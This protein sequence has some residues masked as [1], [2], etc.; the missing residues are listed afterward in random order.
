MFSVSGGISVLQLGENG[1]ASFNISIDKM[2]SHYAS[3]KEQSGIFAGQGGFDVHTG[4]HTQLNG[5]VIASTTTA[6]KNHLDT[7]T[8]GF[9]DIDNHA[10]Y[11][12]SHQGMGVSTGQFS[13][14][15]NLAGIT[16]GLASNAAS[17]ILSGLSDSGHA[18]STTHAAISEGSITVRDKANQQQDVNSLSRDT[19]HTSQGLRPI[20]DKEKAQQ[21]LAESQRLSEIGRQ[22]ADIVR[23]NGEIQV[24]AALKA[25][26]QAV[27]DAA[28]DNKITESVMQRYGTGSDLQR[29]IQAATAALQGLAG[30]NLSAAALDAA[31]PY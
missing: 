8:L 28:I 16:R 30:G 12:V 31:S 2:N 18:D 25:S 11:S 22:D 21:R 6:D 27:S 14:G 3:V 13:G 9:S 17:S 23:T 1:T 4:K 10:D 20:F 7:G 5:G 26:G 29:G 19:E 24:A 15:A